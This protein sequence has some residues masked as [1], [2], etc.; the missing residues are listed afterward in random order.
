MDNYIR[1]PNRKKRRIRINNF[2]S[3][4]D[5]SSDEGV[6]PK[7]VASE[8]YN[9]DFL[10]G[11]L[12]DG[13]GVV[14]SALGLGDKI[15]NAWCFRKG[16]DEI[17]MV[18][19]SDGTIKFLQN[20]DWNV[21]E[22]IRLLG[23]IRGINYR[24][25]DEDVI[26]ICSDS[27]NMVV[28]N[29]VHSAYSVP[30]SPKIASL[31]LHFERLFVA[32]T[33]GETIRFSQDLDPTNWTSS[34]NEG[35]YIKL[36]DDRGRIGKL[37]SF[38]NHIYIFREFGI[39]R[40]TAFGDQREFSVSNLFVSSGR[41]FHD[42]VA[43]IGDRIIFLAS[44][45]LYS[46]DGLSARKILTNLEGLILPDQNAWAHGAAGRYYLSCRLNG[47]KRIGCENG[48]FLNNGLI[49]IEH[50]QGRYSLTRGVDINRFCLWQDNLMVV[51][52]GNL[53]K[54]EN[55][56]KNFGQILEK[57]WLSPKTDLGVDS[58]KVLEEILLESNVDADLVVESESDKKAF[59]IKGGE[60]INRIRVHL[61]GRKIRFC[62]RTDKENARINRPVLV[63]SEL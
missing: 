12:T 43:L 47:S 60:G 13:Y 41:I 54:I 5:Y 3:G 56:N 18:Q 50:W 35:G 15:K 31:S 59:R 57:M 63:V 16:G 61:R 24:L 2:F 10:S 29:G 4:M 17:L 39:S 49:V 34:L 40:L 48:E 44:D 55:A 53:G 9:F 42:T 36:V 1:L 52:N 46:F 8:N 14:D 27:E 6:L 7:H 23:N 28:W 62:I 37:V 20:G 19:T 32:D 30:S 33:D 22:G 26:L 51:S 21:L 25:L 45:G 38:L 11:A 58:E